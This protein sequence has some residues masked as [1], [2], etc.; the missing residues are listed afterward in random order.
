MIDFGYATHAGRVREHNE[1]NYRVDQELGLWVI[2]DG[3]GGHESGEVASQIVVD[4]IYDKM[5]LGSPLKKAIEQAHE[6]VILAAEQR[7]GLPGMGSTVVALQ[8]HPDHF[9]IAWVGDSRA[10]LW[11]NNELEQITRDHSFVQ[12][13][14]DSGALSPE[15][16][17]N[18][19]HKNIITQALGAHDLEQINVGLVRIPRE[20]GQSFLLCSDGLTDE[21][22]LTEMKEMLAQQEDNQTKVDQLLNLALE[23]GGKD[24]ITIIL[25]SE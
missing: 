10:Y 17:E 25:V 15:E 21:V 14:V 2:A 13:M 6:I 8:E 19:P 12:Q 1:D 24:N 11:K 7:L 9:E 3:M 23:H 20:P 18:H 16:A 22:S 4:L 5:K